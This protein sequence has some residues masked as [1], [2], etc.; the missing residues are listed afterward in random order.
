[1]TNTRQGTFALIGI[2][3]LIIGGGLVYFS[4]RRYT[5]KRY[6]VDAASCRMQVLAIERKDLPPNADLG[7]VIL[8]HGISANNIIM[9]YIARAFAEQGLRV[10]VPDLPGHGRS[11]GPFL[12]AQAEAC[13]ASLVRGLA[14]RGMINPSRTILSG[15]SMGGAIALR[16]AEKFRPA[17]VIVFSPAPMQAAHG[18]TPEKLLFNG[19]PKILPNTR[20]IVGQFEHPGLKANAAD[21][22][23]SGDPSV[24]YVVV[25]W[26]THVTILFSPAAVREA[27]AW[28]AN[29]LGL[30]GEPR[31]PNRLHLVAC[32]LGLFGIL[33][34]SGPLLR[35]LVAAKPPRDFSAVPTVPRWR[36][37]LAVALVSLLLIYVWPFFKPL[38]SIR[39]FEGDYLASFFLLFGFAIILLHFSIARKLAPVSLGVFLGAA[40]AGILLHLLITG[41]FELTATSA[42]L[43]LQRWVRFPL[44]AVTAFLFFY[45]LEALA[46]PAATW[47]ARFP[48][49]F[50]LVVLSWLALAFGVLFLKSGEILLVLLSPYFA[51]FFLLTGT[52][53]HLVRRLTGSATAAAVFGAIL[54]AGFCLVLFPV[55]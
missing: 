16:V 28:A 14:A 4:S 42:W 52:G 29:I 20:V 8:F 10:F 49:W 31:L 35:E 12:P 32:F 34:L 40:A 17:G 1:M 22:V 36:G 6:I 43:T 53:I 37:A 45:A 15:H 39:L 41:W 27:Q 3:C 23:P 11:P 47:R 9:D 25:P 26:A 55:T 21:L 44:F 33:L 13:S 5:E 7:S 54:L 46:G 2:L 38:K 48:F 24:Q 30:T 51:T 50:S 18:V 19:V